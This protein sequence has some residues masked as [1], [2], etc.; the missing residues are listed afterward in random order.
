MKI[1]EYFNQS[2]PLIGNKWI[3]I[4]SFSF[5]VPLFMII[6]QP[7]GLTEY[8]G[9]DKLAR[10]AGYGFV[11]FVILILNLFFITQLIKHWYNEKSW[12]VIRQIYWLIWIVFTIGLANFLYS[13]FIFS[14][15]SFKG[16][17][18]F[19][20]YTLEVGIIPIVVLT[21]LQ[22][23]LML[24]RNLKSA[25][26][27]NNNLSVKDDIKDDEKIIFISDNEKDKLEVKLS[28]ML[29]LESTKNYIEIFQYNGDKLIN[30][31]L[32]CSLKRI[33]LQIANYSILFKCHRSFII[34]TSKVIQ[35]KGNSQGLKL[36]LKHTET[37]I[38]VS[39]NLTKDLKAKIVQ[40]NF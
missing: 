36:V 22:Q 18:I 7:F 8:H 32:R 31:L 4:L 38:P 3:I 9:T 28:N 1:K 12:T 11:T 35:V 29:Y 15:G 37:E 26:E 25:K 39:R 2:Y 40:T 34:N 5:F 23:N 27:V 33:E 30:N 20:L 19:Q 21:I 10:I 14:F 13:S 24:N 16:L 17:I 6:F